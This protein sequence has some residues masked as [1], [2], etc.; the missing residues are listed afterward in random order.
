MLTCLVCLDDRV[1]EMNRLLLNGW[2]PKTVGRKFGINAWTMRN[3]RKRHLPWR[4]RSQKPGETIEEQRKDL[5]YELERL[6][7]LAQ[8]GDDVT[9]ALRVIKARQSLLELQMR[10]EHLLG[11][12]HSR[13][14]PA[15][16]PEGDFVVE[17]EGGRPRTVKAGER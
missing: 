12:T 5:K 6:Q 2:P 16:K 8:C 7:V 14:M 11:A 15:R 4:H 17:F 9:E 1:K 3:H 10:G 13:L